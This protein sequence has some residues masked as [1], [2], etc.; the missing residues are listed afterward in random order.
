MFRREL[1]GVAEAELNGEVGGVAGT[2]NSSCQVGGDARAED[3]VQVPITIYQSD[4]C[5]YSTAVIPIAGGA[6]GVGE[7]FC[8]AVGVIYVV[9]LRR[10]NAMQYCAVS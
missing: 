7:T 4:F 2:V 10:V 3:E 9:V 1:E 8:G 5:K 6:F